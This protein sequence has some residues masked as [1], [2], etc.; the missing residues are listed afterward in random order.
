M[1]KVQGE[2]NDLSLT[3]RTNVKVE[4][5]LSSDLYRTDRQTDRYRPTQR[6]TDT[7]THMQ[8]QIFFDTGGLNED[9]PHRAIG[10]VTSRRYG[11]VGRSVSLGGL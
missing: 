9:G 5:E 3:S 6:Q 2:A 4:R 8:I 11:L 7:H 10:S 1:N